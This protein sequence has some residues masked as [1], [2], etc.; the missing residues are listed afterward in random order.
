MATVSSQQIKDMVVSPEFRSQLSGLPEMNREVEGFDRWAPLALYGFYSLVIVLSVLFQ[1]GM[2]LYY[3][4][5]RKRV[6]A[7]L[8][9]PEWARRL[10]LEQAG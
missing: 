9:S 10:V 5:R 7:F 4:T 1:G 6:A 2:S 3:F 8:Q